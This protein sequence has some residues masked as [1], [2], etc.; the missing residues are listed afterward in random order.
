MARAT[1]T[2]VRQRNRA[3]LAPTLT[4]AFWRLRKTWG[5]LLVTGLGIVMAVILACTVPLY[6]QVAPIISTLTR[7]LNQEV[8]HHLG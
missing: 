8:E 5:L 4:L 6:S 1:R 3:H 7:Q 2:I